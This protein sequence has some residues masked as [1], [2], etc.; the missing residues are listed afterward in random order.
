MPHAPIG[1]L[2]KGLHSKPAPSH[3]AHHSRT[4]TSVADE[5]VP[6]FYD[7]WAKVLDQQGVEVVRAKYIK[8]IK[9]TDDPDREIMFDSSKVRLGDMQEWLSQKSKPDHRWN[10]VTAYSAI[11][12]AV[13]TLLTLITMLG[14]D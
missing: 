3:S 14:Q 6:H 10:M 7:E 8:E 11:A 1:E 9:V 12:V 13:L 2:R 4:D 5:V